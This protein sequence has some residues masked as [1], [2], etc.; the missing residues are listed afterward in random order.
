MV[1]DLIDGKEFVEGL[2]ARIASVVYVLVYVER[3]IPG[4]KVFQ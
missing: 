2:I 1:V 3:L 4:Q